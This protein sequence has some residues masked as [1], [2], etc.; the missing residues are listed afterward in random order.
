MVNESFLEH[1]ESL[2]VDAEEAMYSDGTA[3]EGA[4]A[5]AR[6][7]AGEHA[8]PQQTKGAVDEDGQ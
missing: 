4:D 2:I 5:V 8:G 6:Q 3:V 1:R 7:G